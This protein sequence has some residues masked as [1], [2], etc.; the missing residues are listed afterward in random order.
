AGSTDSVTL[1]WNSVSG[2]T[3]YSVYRLRLPREG[4]YPL[5]AR[6]NG[7]ALTRTSFTHT[8][9]AS[10]TPYYYVVTATVRCQESSPSP[11]A[12]VT[13][14][15]TGLTPR[16][17]NVGG[18]AVTTSTGAAWTADANFTGG[19]TN[20]TTQAIT[21]TNDPS[22]YQDERWGDFSYAVPVA[23]GTYD[24]RLHFAE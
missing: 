3:G 17:I 13:A 6:A 10:G 20:S 12:H 14:R 22:L 16:R 24:V 5:G 21:G 23:N 15:N 4:G 2:A 18:P 8:G 7:G 1:T 9:L 19:S 11:A